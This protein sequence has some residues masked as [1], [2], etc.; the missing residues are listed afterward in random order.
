MIEWV[1]EADNIKEQIIADRRYLHEHAEYGMD[2]PETK[3]YVKK[4][5]LDMGYEPEDCGGGIVVMAGR[6]GGRTILIR[7][8]MDA[9]KIEEDNELPFRSR[10]DVSHLCGHDL[11]TAILLGTAALLKENEEQLAG[12]V[13]LMFQPGEEIAMG[14]KAMISAGVLENPKVD[15]ALSL[16]VMSHIQN[17]ILS[18][19]VGVAFSSADMFTIRIEGKSAHSSAPE[20]AVDPIRAGVQVYQAIEGIVARETSMFHSAVCTIG[21]FEGGK[22]GNIIPE[23]AVLEGS[24]RCYDEEDRKRI[25]SRIT[26]VLEGIEKA[27][28]TK[29]TMESTGMTVL[30][31]DEELC[32]MLA[33]VFAAVPGLELREDALPVNA[34]EDFGYVSEK[35]PTM[36]LMFGV[37][38]PGMPINHNAKAIFKD[39]KIH[40][41][42]AAFAKAAEQYLRRKED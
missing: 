34:S 41:A 42:S 2:L 21:H 29:I 36:Y 32:R 27:S 23:Y 39:S 1:K 26:D 24:L 19:K 5:L 31:N 3:A 17:G 28:G 25:M 8:D 33:P 12:T 35:V 4:R 13:K 14:A 37:G 30:E 18:Y 22:M 10:T 38:E 16:H 6:G 40:L 15:A 20:Y 9:L 7:A 11:H